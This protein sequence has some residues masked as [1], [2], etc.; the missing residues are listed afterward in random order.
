M[1]YLFLFIALIAG[2]TKGALGK[3]LSNTVITHKQSVF[4]NL[5]RMFLC[6]V[7]SIVVLAVQSGGLNIT[8]DMPALIYGSMAGVTLSVFTITW[9]LSMQHGAYMLVSIAQSFGMV[10]ALVGSFLVFREEIT[11]KKISGVS[12]L[13]LAVFVVASYSSRIKGKLTA[14]A[15]ILLVLCGS[16]CGLY[17]FSQKLFTAF[18]KAEISTLNLLTYIISALALLLFYMVPENQNSNKINPRELFQKTFWMIMIMSVSLF[19]NSYFMALS[20]HYLTAT[21]LY[22]ISRAGGMIAAALMSAIFFGEKITF[23]CV[24]GISLSFVAILLLK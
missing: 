23:R 14:K 12:I 9:L 16:S 4:V 3:K 18:S 21:Q 22:P 10:V 13:I 19:V 8:I 2:T 7:I 24:L 17:D 11:I 5:I 20:T 1:G 15:I 6:T